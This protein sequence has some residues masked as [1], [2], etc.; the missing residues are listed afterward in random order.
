MWKEMSNKT[1][2]TEGYF[3]DLIGHLAYFEYIS[4]VRY[5]TQGFEDIVIILAFDEISSFLL[6][7]PDCVW[8]LFNDDI[9]KPLC[10]ITDGGDILR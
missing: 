9:L 7:Y 8:I 6:H 4:R 3:D 5:P 1:D 2:Y 10:G